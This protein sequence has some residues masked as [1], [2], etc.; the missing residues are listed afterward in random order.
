MLPPTALHADASSACSRLGHEDEAAEV[1]A[2]APTFLFPRDH[3]CVRFGEEK[4]ELQGYVLHQ[5]F[6]DGSLLPAGAQEGVRGRGSPRE[7]LPAEAARGGAVPLQR[8]PAPSGRKKR[9]KLQLLAPGSKPKRFLS[10]RLQGS[11]AAQ[12][13]LPTGSNPP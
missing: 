11:R 2:A 9:K 4:V 12:T 3:F 1:A 10:R 7:L 6:Q 8:A 5:V 13:S